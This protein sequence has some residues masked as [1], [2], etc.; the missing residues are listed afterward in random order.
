MSNRE[1]ILIIQSLMG[2]LNEINHPQF[3]GLASKKK[4]ELLLI[5]QQ[6]KIST[7]ELK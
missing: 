6:L 5:L 1:L 3:K 2:S 7:M 4:E